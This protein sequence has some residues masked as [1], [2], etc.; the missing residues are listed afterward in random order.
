MEIIMNLLLM[1]GGVAVFMFGMKQMSSGL[2]KSAGS[3]IRNLF[4][5]IDKNRVFNYGIGIGATALVQSSSATSIMTVGL[6]HANIV[7]VKQGSGFILGAKLGTTLTAFIFALSGISKG[8]FSISSVFAAIAFVGVM[9]IFSTSN[10][11]LN[12]IAP[13]FIGFGML[14][15]GMEVMETAIGGADSMLSIQLSKVFEYEIMQNPILLVI[16]GILFTAIIQ[17]STAATGVFIAFLAAGVIHSIDQ[18]FFLVMGANIGTC[19]DGIMASLTTN[20]NGKRIALFHLLTSVIGAISFTIILV[21]FRTPITN[22]FDSLFSGKPQFSL[23]TFN[24]IYNAIYTLVL[25][26]FIDPLVKLVTRMVKDKEQKVEEVSYIDERFLKTPAVAIEQALRELYDMAILA[27]ENLDRSFASLVNEDMSES[28]KIAEV[29]YR[30]DFLTNKL[31]SFFIKISTVTK[32]A[33]D[34]K[35]IG[36]L[37][38]VT[39]DIERLGDY[40]VLL[41]KETSYME[42]N[43]VKFLDQTKEELNQI[44]G[45]IS[46][47]FDL[48][49]DAFT[50]RRTENFRTISNIHKEIKKLISSTRNEHVIRLSSGMYPVE[51]SKS[52]YSVLF[53]LQRISDH[54]VNIAFSIRS[55]T[56][57]K[58][59]ALQAIEQEMEK[60]ESERKPSQEA[61]INK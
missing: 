40:A 35:L 17:S 34:E 4:K 47:M 56:G 44:Y 28:K 42:Q 14:F 3:G 2:E 27:K 18:S 9:I 6:A 48:G 22:I 20:A 51:V 25:L 24:L 8:G 15:I 53:S 57:S 60:N 39:N 55:T 16:L 30:I 49:F 54:I 50:K 61:N 29:E 1:L 13:F 26:A 11:T 43:D 59:E 45:H 21:I 5:K 33:G 10:E 36:G 7:T 38:H 12:K 37:H 58:T 46:E 32:F 52:I 19:S 41:V 23:A 31:T